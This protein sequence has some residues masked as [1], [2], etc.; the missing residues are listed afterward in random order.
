MSRLS[1]PLSAQLILLTFVFYL[2]F[3]SRIIVA[4]LLPELER[5]LCIS[6]SK[7]GTFFLCISIGYFVSL[8]SSGFISTRLGHKKTIVLCLLAIALSMFLISMSPSLLLL[9]MAFFFTGISTGLYLPSGIAT[10][11]SL[12][13]TERRGKAFGIHEIAPNLAFLTA[14]LITSWL[15][16]IVEWQHITLLLS[17]VVCCTAITYA[18]VGRASPI[19]STPP[20]LAICKELLSLP[21]FWL[22][23]IL[24]TMAITATHG[25][26]SVLPLFLVNK[27]AMA[28]ADANM[29]IGFSRSTTLVTAFLGGWMADRFGALKTIT[30]VMLLTGSITA[31]LGIVSGPMLSVIIWFQP[32][33]AVCFFAPAFFLL[34]QVGSE[35]GKKIVISLAIPMAFVF[36]GGVIPAAITKM[37]DLG[38]FSLA[39]FLAGIFITSGT[40]L[41]RLMPPQQQQTQE[42]SE[43]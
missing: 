24:F 22:M 42:D 25:I 32:M 14:P 9:Q 36:G 20:D 33:I 8:L 29:L 7:A 18:L 5:A 10:I 35:N 6:H 17:G 31:L 27:H 2:N 28:A 43:H 26:F 13:T 15:L 1:K 23:V 4:P 12:Y 3:F 34:S 19:K 21:R 11:T 30:V 39:L 38:Y 41:I 37:A 40:L 16:P